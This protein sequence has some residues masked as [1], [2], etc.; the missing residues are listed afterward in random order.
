MNENFYV[1]IVDDDS[2]ITDQLSEY[3]HLKYNH[4]RITTADNAEK[5]LEYLENHVFDLIVSDINLP[6]LNG[7]QL[8]SRIREKNQESAII[9]ITGFATMQSVVEAINIGVDSYIIKPFTFSD[10]DLKINEVMHKREIARLNNINQV[11][12]DDLEYKNQLSQLVISLSSIN[13]LK[14]FVQRACNI[15]REM[16][17]FSNIL[18]WYRINRREEAFYFTSYSHRVNDPFLVETF[19]QLGL[20]LVPEQWA[21]QIGKR[22]ETIAITS[23]ATSQQLRQ[24][25]TSQKLYDKN[26]W[27]IYLSYQFC[28]LNENINTKNTINLQLTF[29]IIQLLLRN[30][31]LIEELDYNSSIDG[32]T[33]AY[34]H[35]FFYE[36]LDKSLIRAQR[37]DHPLSVVMLDVDNFKIV[38]DKFG[39]IVGDQVLVDL[40]QIILKS[41]RQ[42]DILARY[43][44]DEFAIIF[45]NCAVDHT[46]Q[47]CHRILDTIKLA[48]ITKL[49]ENLFSISIG[50]AEY[51]Q[52][53]SE[54]SQE[55]LIK[56]DSALY[57]AKHSGKSKIFYYE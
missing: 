16:L 2:S 57:E 4:Y 7:N 18:V 32:L 11:L 13:R 54:S 55:L 42:S 26:G 40:V 36:F 46:L 25:V 23:I 38:N 31:I 41:I 29:D 45:P 19:R 52:S 53:K 15:L 6:G 5:A 21:D 3:L 24:P 28:Q 37:E 34:N 50:I 14:D 47:I 1:L 17:P 27:F 22:L 48:P 8:A 35:R 39:H 44:G 20:D 49:V 12:K 51:Q 10:F 30:V 9:L 56:A 33:K 43:G